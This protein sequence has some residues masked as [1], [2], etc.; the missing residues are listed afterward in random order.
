MARKPRSNNNTLVDA[1]EDADGP[2]RP[3]FREAIY[4]AADGLRLS[5]R[6]YGNPL[7]PWLPVVC[8]AGFTRDSRDFHELASHLSTHRH[9][10][11]RVV[12]FDSR[13]RGRSE[14]AQSAESYNLLTE[15][16][17]ALD[18]MAALNIPRAV[19]VGT[20]RGGIIGMLMGLARPATV[21]GLVLND[22]GPVIEA[23]GLMRIKTYVGRTPQPNDWADAAHIL[24]RIHAAGFPSWRDVDWDYYARLT[25]KDDGDRPVSAYDAKLAQTLDGIEPGET[26]PAMWEEFR[27][28]KDIPILSIRGEH[29]DLLSAAT[30]ARMSGE[31]PQVETVTVAGEGHA[32]LLRYGQVLARVSAFVTAIEGNGPPADAIIPRDE[33][34]YDLDAVA[35]PETT[36]VESAEQAG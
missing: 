4:R 6:D 8:L 3:V 34:G 13:G 5:A 18:G 19:V 31:H 15:M 2:A 24:S 28:L 22:V 21:A 30:V 16:N 26:L 33:A 20:S 17:D 1:G 35:E 23:Q 7:S 36:D 25:F 14:W 32:P 9:R 29:S 11:R 10:P 27:A 12:A